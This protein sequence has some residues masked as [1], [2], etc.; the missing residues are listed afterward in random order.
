MAPS[1]PVPRRRPSRQAHALS[2]ERLARKRALDREAQ[3]HSRS[4]TKNHIALLESRIE[5]LTRV[6]E[7]GDTKELVEKIEEQ[8]VENDALRKTL[9]SIGKI[10]GGDLGGREK[11]R[12][13]DRGEV[14]RKPITPDSDD[15][16]KVGV[17]GDGEGEGEGDLLDMGELPEGCELP[18]S[19]YAA[20]N[21]QETNPQDTQSTTMDVVSEDALSLLLSSRS[22]Q[23]LY[24]PF[25]LPSLPPSLSIP[26]PPLWTNHAPPTSCR[27]CKM[28]NFTTEI[29][30][31]C[32]SLQLHNTANQRAR[33][34]DI[35]IRAILHGWNAVTRRY[36]LDPIWASLRHAD[37]VLLRACGEAERLVVLRNLCVMLRVCLSSVPACNFGRMSC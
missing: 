29:L 32:S 34:A 16:E 24:T 20:L 31:T 3:R 12:E 19:C 11:E 21:T 25:T 23:P 35:P 15:Y 10:I 5:A 28:V 14:E 9:A 17:E 30:T 2:D 4:K 33:D 22:T 36:S 6:R 27:C 37:E 1:S 18:G 7:N 8:R 13:R 26:L